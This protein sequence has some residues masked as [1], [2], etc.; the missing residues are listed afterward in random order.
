M[1]I[2]ER[3]PCDKA[4]WPDGG[5]KLTMFTWVYKWS[6]GCQGHGQIRTLKINDQTVGALASNRLNWW[7]SYVQQAFFKLWIYNCLFLKQD[8]GVLDP[9]EGRVPTK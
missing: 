5:K 7:I 8:Y 3:Y 2:S 6:S 9:V 4:M 1:A